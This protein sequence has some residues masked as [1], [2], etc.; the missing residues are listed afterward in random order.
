MDDATEQ[1]RRLAPGEFARAQFLPWLW[2]VKFEAAKN[3]AHVADK[4]LHACGGPA[5][6]PAW[7]SSATCATARP[8]G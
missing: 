1:Q 5:T 2:Q 8:A 4:M 3:V 6:S 7:A